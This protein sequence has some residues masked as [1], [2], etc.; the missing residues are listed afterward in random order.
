VETTLSQYQHQ[1]LQEEKEEKKKKNKLKWKYIPPANWVFTPTSVLL[2][3]KR[4]TTTAVTILMKQ[5]RG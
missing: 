2:P 3:K 1:T 5:M 4:M